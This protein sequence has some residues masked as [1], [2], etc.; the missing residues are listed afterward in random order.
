[1]S[2]RCALIRISSAAAAAGLL[3]GT[4]DQIAAAAAIARSEMPATEYP[5]TAPAADARERWRVGDAT[6]RGLRLALIALAGQEAPR[7][8]SPRPNDGAG[9]PRA[10]LDEP[11]QNWRVGGAAPDVESRIRDRFAASVTGH[12][13]AVQADRIATM[14]VD[15]AQLEALP[16]NELVSMTVR[17]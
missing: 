5:G 14:F 16:V 15:R 7:S 3:G 11:A 2:A 8:V 4:R 17:N 9:L 6:S 1:M 12:F 10:V 13:P